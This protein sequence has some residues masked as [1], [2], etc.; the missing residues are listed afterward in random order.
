M[1]IEVGHDVA[2][3][4]RTLNK[5]VKAVGDLTDRISVFEADVL[6]VQVRE[7]DVFVSLLSANWRV[8]LAEM[9]IS[10]GVHFVRSSDIAPEMK[11]L[12]DKALSRGVSCVNEAGLV[13]VIDHLDGTT[14]CRWLLDLDCY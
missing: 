9:C 6:A 14:P 10:K 4:N 12:H 8:S 3:W 1:L 11:A 2:V 7:G 5:A 13:S